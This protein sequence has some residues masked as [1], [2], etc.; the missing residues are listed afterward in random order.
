MDR[1]LGELRKTQAAALHS[2]LAQRSQ[3]QA[4]LEAQIAEAEA[5]A[6][7]QQKLARDFEAAAQELHGELRHVLVQLQAKH[8][9]ATTERRRLEETGAFVGG[10]ARHAACQPAGPDPGLWRLRQSGR[11]PLG[12]VRLG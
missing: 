3:A 9:N 10:S 4:L 11:G 1:L 8:Q 5:E 7:L 6:E 12:Q 2:Q